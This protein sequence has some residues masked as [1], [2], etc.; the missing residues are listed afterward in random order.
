M[1]TLQ[2]PK[3]SDWNN[4]WSR[5]QSQRFSK[6]SWSKQRIIQVLAP[7][8]RKGAFALDAGCGSGFFTRFFSDQGMSATA[9][10]YSDSALKMAAEATKGAAKLVRAD[11]VNE[12]LA[13]LMAERFDLVFTDGLFEHFSGEDQDKIM[14]N[15]ISVLKPGGYIITF[16]PNL[17]SPWELIRPF[18]MPGIEEKPFVLK[19]LLDLN[20]R[21]DLAVVES[22]GVN[23]LPFG[24][25]PEFLGPKFGMLL[26]TVAK[27]VG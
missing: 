17:L 2:N 6:L 12:N 5:E 9:L 19:G 22:G 7:R 27:K 4:F 23:V 18:Y 13:E 16:V 25:S 26:Y 8:C 10:D 3:D 20:R 14:Q 21:N 24:L 11:M 15:L 1:K